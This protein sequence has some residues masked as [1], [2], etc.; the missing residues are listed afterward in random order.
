[1][2]VMKSVNV[3]AERRCQ[4]QW[5]SLLR[6]GTCSC[7]LFKYKYTVNVDIAIKHYA[8]VSKC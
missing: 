4:G 6:R 1:M 2:S 8:Y 7:N 3:V 5:S